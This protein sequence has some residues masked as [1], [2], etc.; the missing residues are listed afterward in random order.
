MSLWSWV[1]MIA[2][3]FLFSAG[4]WTLARLRSGEPRADTP[5]PDAPDPHAPEPVADGPARPSPDRPAPAGLGIRSPVW[6]TPSRAALGVSMML[7]GYHLVVWTMPPTATNLQVPRSVWWVVPL[8]CAALVTLSRAI[9]LLEA[10]TR[11]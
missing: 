4:I 11:S 6:S 7:V 2:G 3:V 9:D 8:A 10:R 5:R 1:M